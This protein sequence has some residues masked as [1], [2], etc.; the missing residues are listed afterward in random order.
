MLILMSI[1][2]YLFK[3]LTNPTAGASVSSVTV[4][5]AAGRGSHHGPV[6]VAVVGG[7]WRGGGDI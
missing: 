7:T 3:D 1:V 6:I 5:P 4:T 2:K